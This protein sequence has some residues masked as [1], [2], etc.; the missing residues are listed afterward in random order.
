MGMGG[1]GGGGGFGA[2]AGPPPPAGPAGYGGGFGAPPMSAAAGPP[3]RRSAAAPS[4]PAS[5]GGGR[6]GG[7]AGAAAPK[8]ERLSKESAKKKKGKAMS[9]FK[10]SKDKKSVNAAENMQ[11]AD[12]SDDLLSAAPSAAV[13]ES[14]ADSYAALAL[15]EDASSDDD[16]DFAA[17]EEKEEEAGAASPRA[18]SAG[19]ASELIN[20]QQFNGSYKLDDSLARTVG[21]TLA[22]LKSAKSDDKLA[23]LSTDEAWAT[24]LALASFEKHHGSASDMWS[25]VAEKA[26]NY[27]I[28]LLKA[29]GLDRKAARVKLDELVALA[30]SAL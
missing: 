9:F 11:Y 20:L 19:S 10:S 24:L 25:M 13:S 26:K 3:M 16:D 15:D 29:A 7:R 12:L 18:S 23:P 8:M 4:R 27:L 1:G 14:R 22:S 21:S 6:A 28:G 5:R 2:P 17:E 30:Q